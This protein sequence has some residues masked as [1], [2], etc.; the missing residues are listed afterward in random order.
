MA[1]ITPTERK[2]IGL[3]RPEM[4][5]FWLT[6]NDRANTE[7]G[8]R[9]AVPEHGG[10]RST[11]EQ[12]A[13]YADSLQQ[14]GGQL[15]YAVGVPGHSRHQYG[16]AIDGDIIAGGS[17]ADGTGSDD[18]YKRLA[19]LAEEIGLEAGYYFDVR[20][21]SRK[22]PYHFQLNEPLQ[23]SIDRWHAML[24]A[25]IGKAMLASIAVVGLGLLRR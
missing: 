16:S 23:Q 11:K 25:G 9:I 14:G 13:L 17:N 6:L 21:N 18:D 15:A 8:Y 3:V 22:D 1:T 19:D 10:T 5:T 20:Y 24:A 4:W 2:R 7:L 12:A